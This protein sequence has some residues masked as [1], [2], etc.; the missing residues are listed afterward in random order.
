VPSL[1]MRAL[2]TPSAPQARTPAAARSAR[3]CRTV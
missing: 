3:R 1:G 2:A